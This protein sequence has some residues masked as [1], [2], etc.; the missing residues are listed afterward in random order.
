MIRTQTIV[1]VA[2]LPLPPP[3]PLAP[4]QGRHFRVVHVVEDW[5]RR[6]EVSE[7]DHVMKTKTK[8]KDLKEDGEG[9]GE[10]EEKKREG[11][12]MK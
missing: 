9:V 2:L 10:K 5:D 4:T 6:E 3:P 11:E 12:K 7:A 8:T 1:R